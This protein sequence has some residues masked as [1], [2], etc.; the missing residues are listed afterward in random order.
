MDIKLLRKLR[1]KY[2]LVQTTANDFIWEKRICLTFWKWQY[3]WWDEA[4]IGSHEYGYYHRS[5]GHAISCFVKFIHGKYR[6]AGYKR[7]RIYIL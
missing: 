6:E 2:R 5:R 4:T 1:G 7:K 3:C